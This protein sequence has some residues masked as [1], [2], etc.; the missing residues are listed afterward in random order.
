M[1]VDEL[2]E[3]DGIEYCVAH[4]EVIDERNG[5]LCRA[6]EFDYADG[7]CQPVA[8]YFLATIEGTS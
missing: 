1:T 2:R 6:A 4:D 3:V 7:D 5:A 8:L